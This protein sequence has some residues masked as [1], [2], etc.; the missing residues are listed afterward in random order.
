MRIYWLFLVLFIAGGCTS[1]AP[2]ASACVTEPAQSRLTAA[3]R[4]ALA[5]S[6]N[7]VQTNCQTIGTKC[8]FTVTRNKIG[9]LIVGVNFLEPHTCEQIAGNYKID[10][11]DSNG[12]YQFTLPGL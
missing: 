4:V 12:K 7:S 11:Y 6:K 5:Y 3:E 2:P 9:Q 10:V 1:N 8:A